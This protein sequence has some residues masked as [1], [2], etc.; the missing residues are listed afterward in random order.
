MGFTVNQLKWL[1][2]DDTS[3]SHYYYAIRNKIRDA[4]Q[5][6]IRVLHSKKAEMFKYDLLYVVLIANEI[7]ERFGID[8]F[9]KDVKGK[10]L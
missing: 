4:C 7:I 9:E 6:I 2:S 5:T 8:A 10:L 3:K 1:N